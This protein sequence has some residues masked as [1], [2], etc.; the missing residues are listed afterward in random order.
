MSRIFRMRSANLMWVAGVPT[1]TLP[2]SW[3]NPDI[4]I[5]NKF[6]CKAQGSVSSFLWP[7]DKNRWG[8][9]GK[10]QLGF[11][12]YKSLIVQCVKSGA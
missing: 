5:R 10:T 9:C 11:V 7:R 12:S 1:M 4:V 3:T 6:H 8:Q 2:E